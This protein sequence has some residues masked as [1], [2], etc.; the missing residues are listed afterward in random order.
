MTDTP[1]PRAA[2]AARVHDDASAIASVEVHKLDAPRQL[3]GAEADAVFTPRSLTS[4][5]SAATV[6]IEASPMKAQLLA[7][8]RWVAH[9]LGMWLI[10]HGFSASQEV[11]LEPIAAG[12]L[13]SCGSLALSIVQK[14]LV[15]DRI[16]L[17]A[18]TNPANV[19]LR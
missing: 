8:A 5:P 9:G 11:A 4:P 16:Y 13:L 1:T 6:K 15:S 7:L 18:K 3:T 19:V 17:A 12:L 14:K 2:D 10:L